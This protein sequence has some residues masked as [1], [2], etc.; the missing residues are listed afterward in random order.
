MPFIFGNII[1]TSYTS[2]LA[3]S[4]VFAM[5]E[6]KIN[7]TLKE[8][9]SLKDKYSHDL[10]NIL[11]SMSMTYELIRG[12]SISEKELTEVYNLLKNKIYEA[13]DLVRFI[14]EL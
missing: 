10:G 8:K 2:I 11:Q 1:V 4:G 6:Q 12:K 7:S 9:N 14:R 3:V 5:L 13:S